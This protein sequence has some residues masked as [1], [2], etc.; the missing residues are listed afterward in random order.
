MLAS[1]LTI[2]SLSEFG[3]PLPDE[4]TARMMANRLFQ[5]VLDFDRELFATEYES[6]SHALNLDQRVIN[7]MLMR[8]TSCSQQSLVFVYGYG[9]TGKTLSWKTIITNLCSMGKVVLAVAAS[10]IASLLL[11]SGRT[12][13]SRSSIPIELTEESVC[14][15][16]KNSHLSQLLLKTQLIIWDDAPISDQ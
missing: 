8:A 1:G 3:M 10:G 14:S 7:D 13:H 9:G 2:R 15:K 16:N 11:P 5:E 4:A 12:A 6:I